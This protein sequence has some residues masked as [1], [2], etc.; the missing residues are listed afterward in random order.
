VTALVTAKGLAM[1]GRL[2]PVTL[3]LQA[4]ELVCVV[5]PNGSGKTSLIHA[6]SLIPPASGAVRISGQDP[7]SEP[8]ARRQRLLGLLPAS[9]EMAW[10]LKSA[11]V[12]G[13]SLPPGT[14]WQWLVEPLDLPS[15]LDRRIDN[16][17]TGERTR[18]LI[19]RVLAP[20]PRLL[21]LDEPMA[22]LEPYWQLAVLA[23]L[24]RAA[25]EGCA[26]LLA[27]HDLGLAQRWA[28]RLLVLQDRRIVGDGAPCTIAEAS[29]IERVFRVE[30]DGS[31][32]R[33]SPSADRRSLL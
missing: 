22:N 25:D 18:V 28:D 31:E 15:L 14:D 6:L 30:R 11:D 9:R 10:P 17:S 12:I 24:R 21:L 26:V 7:A 29:L 20:R 4:G 32:W 3:E 8:P 16:L 5:G 33:I 27:I 2:E 1:E 23:L 13:L 19:A